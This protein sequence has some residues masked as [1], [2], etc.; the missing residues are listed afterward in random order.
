MFLI[1]WWKQATQSNSV[2]IF[3]SPFMVVFHLLGVL[4]PWSEFTIYVFKRH[5]REHQ[6]KQK[7][8]SLPR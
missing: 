6:T 7:K 3:Q 1:S 5:R 8:A 4:S 2:S